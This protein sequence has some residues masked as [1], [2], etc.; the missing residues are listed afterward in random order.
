MSDSKETIAFSVKIEGVDREIK[1]LKDLKQAKKDATD[2][3]IRGDKDAAKALAELADKTGDLKDATKSLEGEGVEKLNSSFGLL[4][5]GF[6]SFDGEKIKTAF[7]GIGAAMKAIPLLLIVEG[8]R[9]LIENFDEL[10]KGSGIVAKAFRFVGDIITS[11]KDVIYEFT[12]AIGLTNS[13]I[14][15]LGDS[16]VKNA[17]LAKEALANQTAEYDRQIAIAKASGKSA[18]DLEKAKQQA[19]IDTNKSLVE[20]TIA[21]VRNG[22]VLTEEQNKLLTE[23]LNSIKNAK[24]QQQ[25]IT[26]EAEKTERENY[27]KH[28][29]EK[30]KADAE[31]S[32]AKFERE[33]Q[34]KADIDANIKREEDRLKKEAEDQQKAYEEQK[35][36]DILIQEEKDKRNAEARAKKRKQDEEDLAAAKKLKQD[37]Q[38]FSFDVT[39]KSLQAA[40]GLADAFYSYKLSNVKKGSAEELKIEK[41]KFE[42]NKKLQLAQATIQGIQAVLAAY[43][44]GSAIPVI[45]AVAGPAYAALAGVVSA[46][47]IAKIASQKFEGGGST[48]PATGVGGSPNLPSVP[49]APTIAPPS[50]NST[51]INSDGS[52]GGQSNRIA[53]TQTINVNATIGVNEI[54]D[55]QNR[56]QVL[57]KQ[58]TF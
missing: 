42:T 32:R 3:F 23:Q 49:E 7:S 12:D 34:V 53:Q 14:D 46:L 45:G 56:V 54:A 2:A 25:V 21:Y 30:K 52:N 47:N 15:K 26:L 43:S 39:V 50:N 4:R 44:S 41:Q 20:Q 10:S 6:A 9:Y 28:I 51:L 8:I 11:V 57:E 38:N 13:S 36:L 35:L 22:G 27:K 31:Y 37:E 33:Q 18:V 48:A 55:K 29:E 58:S 19:I 1:S 40:Q 17:E 16:M 24:T 5:E